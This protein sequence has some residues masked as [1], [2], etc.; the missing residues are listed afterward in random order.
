MNHFVSHHSKK[1]INLPVQLRA[2]QPSQ[3][4]R[5]GLGLSRDESGL[6]CDLKML[7][8]PEKRPVIDSHVQHLQLGNWDTHTKTLSVSHTK[9]NTQLCAEIVSFWF[10][11]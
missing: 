3:D 7:K 8:P 4:I 2:E 9:V 5:S 6:T 1:R 11:Y 10:I